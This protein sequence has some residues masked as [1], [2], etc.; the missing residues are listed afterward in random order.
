MDYSDIDHGGAYTPDDEP[1]VCEECGAEL[2]FVECAVCDGNGELQ[3]SS[4]P[5]DR[6]ECTAGDGN[7]G[8]WE[9]P[10]EAH[11]DDEF[12]RQPES[13]QDTYVLGGGV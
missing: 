5:D 7:G 8:T 6:Q 13:A 1:G 3:L 10:D 2:V 11:H 4:D 12:L 9:C